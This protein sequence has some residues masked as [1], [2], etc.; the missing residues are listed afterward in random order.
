VITVENRERYRYGSRQ[1]T[2]RGGLVH[3]TERSNKRKISMPKEDAA[4]KRNQISD[5][6]IDAERESY[7]QLVNS[8]EL[9]KFNDSKIIYFQG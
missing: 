2:V 6:P 9:K 3:G 8:D 4:K 5:P 1:S 7:S